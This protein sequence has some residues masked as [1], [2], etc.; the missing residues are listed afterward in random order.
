MYSDGRKITKLDEDILQKL[1]SQVTID[2]FG[3]AI[4]ELVQNSIDAEAKKIIVKVDVTSL[5]A[6][7]CDDGFGMIPENLEKIGERFYTSKLSSSQDLKSISTFGFR[8]EALHS[9]NTIS[10]LHVISKHKSY[11]SS[12]KLHNNGLRKQ[13]MIFDFDKLPTDNGFLPDTIKTEGT[14][15]SFSNLFHNVPIRRDHI[16][17][18]PNYK[19]VDEVRGGI[20][21]SLVKS[22]SVHIV[23]YQ[24]NHLSKELAKLFEVNDPKDKYAGSFKS[25]YGDNLLLHYET[26]HASFRGFKISGFIGNP[27]SKKF[28]F[29][30][31]NGRSFNI[32]AEDLK[33]LNKIFRKLDNVED[34]PRKSTT[35]GTPFY[36]F[37]T[38]VINVKCQ[39]STEELLQDPTKTIYNSKNWEIIFK[40][41]KKMFVSYVESRGLQMNLPHIN[42]DKTPSPKK[43]RTVESPY[44]PSLARFALNT[45]SKVGYLRESEVKGIVQ[46]SDQNSVSPTKASRLKKFPILENG[47]LIA[48]ACKSNDVSDADIYKPKSEIAEL[49]ISKQDFK[50]GNY[51]VIRQIDKKFILLQMNINKTSNLIIVDQHACDER[52]NVERLLREFVETILNQD[53]DLS[54]ELSNPIRLNISQHDHI[55]FDQYRENFKLYGIKYAEDK[56]SFC[57]T[58]LPPIL[59]EKVKDD[60]KFLESCLLQHIYDL[61]NNIKS[62]KL[63]DDCFINISNLPRIIIEIINS[64]SCRSSIMFGDVLSIE[65]MEKMIQDLSNCR[66]PFQCAHGRP[67]IVPLINL[68][69]SFIEK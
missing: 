59:I 11:N 68:S 52:I 60:T 51:R 35:V 14:I 45:H 17:R 49:S 33:D 36:Q 47:G 2:S 3:T 57:I 41:L 27:Q 58:H 46:G 18:L 4:K 66:L 22:P 40:L 56:D 13:S 16:L 15:I 29:I 54:T 34:S 23:V 61:N 24:V 67:S 30:F 31:I 9:L 42:M 25:V 5:S 1:Q 28:Q 12:Y 65:Q 32:P 43:Q 19:L 6:M 39:S 69:D 62:A 10:K 50:V 53:I 64:K 48:R 21:E 20:F 38:F 63:N 7:V 26:I 44:S 8:G 55:L 37:Q